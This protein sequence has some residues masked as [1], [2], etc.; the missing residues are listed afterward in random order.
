MDAN[1]GKIRLTET[2]IADAFT[3]TS[4]NE[5]WYTRDVA[6]YAQL[7]I[8][9]GNSLPGDGLSTATLDSLIVHEIGHTVIGSAAIGQTPIPVYNRADSLREETRAIQG[10]EN[11]YRKANG[12]PLRCSYWTEGDLCN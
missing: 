5:I 3:V 7:K 1:G 12:M 9:E 4:D 11:P 2:P 6:G 8:N 10:Y